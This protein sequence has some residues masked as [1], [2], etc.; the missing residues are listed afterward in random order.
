MIVP[1][2]KCRKLEFA[3]DLELASARNS[4]ADSNSTIATP[5]AHSMNKANEGSFTFNSENSIFT[6]CNV[7]N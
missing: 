1:E 5:Q 2:I 4:A 3:L 6:I 7:L